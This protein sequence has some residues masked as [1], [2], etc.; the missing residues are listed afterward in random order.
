MHAI[1]KCKENEPYGNDVAM[2]LQQNKGPTPFHA[3]G[4]VVLL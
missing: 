2:V 1:S 4:K 3:R